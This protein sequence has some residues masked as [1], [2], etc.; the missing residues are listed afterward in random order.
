VA[1][2]DRADRP[3]IGRAV[4]G[5]EDLGE[6]EEVGG[7]ED[8]GVAIAR[9]EMSPPSAMRLWTWPRRMQSVSPGPTGTASPSTRKV[10]TPSSP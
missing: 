3:W 4:E 5:G 6:L 2:H 1:Q 9:K 10:V 7:A 8:P